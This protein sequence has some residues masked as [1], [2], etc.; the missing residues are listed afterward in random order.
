MKIRVYLV[1]KDSVNRIGLKFTKIFKEAASNTIPALT[2]Y[3]NEDNGIKSITRLQ[4]HSMAFDDAQ[5]SAN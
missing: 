1:F 4:L 5:F 3:F 2:V